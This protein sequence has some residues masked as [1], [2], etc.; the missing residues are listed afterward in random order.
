MWVAKTEIFV[1]TVDLVCNC[2]CS[3]S[4]FVMQLGCVLTFLWWPV[5]FLY[6]LCLFVNRPSLQLCFEH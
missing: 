3:N 6:V 4:R 5:Y 1:S 2:V